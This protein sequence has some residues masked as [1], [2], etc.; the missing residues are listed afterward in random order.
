[1]WADFG[2]NFLSYCPSH[3]CELFAR[4]KVIFCFHLAGQ[5]SGKK[6]TRVAVQTGVSWKQ[7]FPGKSKIMQKENSQGEKAVNI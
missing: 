4:K 1:M 6:G 7:K 5:L 3:R 2:I